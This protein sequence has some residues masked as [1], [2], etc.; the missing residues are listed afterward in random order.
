MR[1]V[2]KVIMSRHL[3]KNSTL[4]EITKEK[5]KQMKTTN[6]CLKVAMKSTPW[7]KKVNVKVT[8]W[9]MGK[10]LKPT[11]WRIKQLKD[12]RMTL[13]SFGRE[14]NEMIRQVNLPKRKK[15][16]LRVKINQLQKQSA[17]LVRCAYFQKKNYG[18]R[19]ENAMDLD[20]PNVGAHFTMSVC[21]NMME[22]CIAQNASN[23]MW[24]HS[25][26]Q[27]HCSKTCSTMMTGQHQQKACLPTIARSSAF[28][29]TT[30]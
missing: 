13:D 12:A 30:S 2:T 26:P 28:T 16:A 24:C 1:K 21:S 18:W 17:I 9:T 11:K 23:K 3:T 8:L 27:R 19:V 4:T 7:S 22:S 25:V 6:C 14:V 10:L 5:K 15:N 29:L 20:A